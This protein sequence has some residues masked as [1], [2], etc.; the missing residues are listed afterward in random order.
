[1]AAA[2]MTWWPF[3][4]LGSGDEVIQHSQLESWQAAEARH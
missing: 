3:V 1:M 4:R 2:L